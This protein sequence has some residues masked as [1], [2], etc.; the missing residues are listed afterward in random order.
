MLPWLAE[1]GFSHMFPPATILHSLLLFFLLTLD[2][3][4]EGICWVCLPS[5]VVRNERLLRHGKVFITPHIT[6]SHLLMEISASSHVSKKKTK[7]KH[8]YNFKNGSLISPPNTLGFV[9]A[10]KHSLWCTVCVPHCGLFG[11]HIYWTKL[12][13]WIGKKKRLFISLF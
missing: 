2:R 1:W 10:L 9:S 13:S 3:H 4:K 5:E 7:K 6:E 11:F 12:V 8:D